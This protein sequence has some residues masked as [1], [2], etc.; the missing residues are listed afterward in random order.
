[1]CH[2]GK[3]ITKENL[4]ENVLKDVLDNLKCKYLYVLV[5]RDNIDISEKIINM[6]K[7]KYH[8]DFHKFFTNN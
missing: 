2:K 7:R 6:N 1:M 8:F 3:V 5:L 4:L